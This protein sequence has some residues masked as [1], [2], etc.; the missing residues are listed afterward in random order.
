[1]IKRLSWAA[2]AGALL[3]VIILLLQPAPTE[4]ERVEK[5]TIRAMKSIGLILK[6]KVKTSP[7]L[8]LEMLT[9]RT[10][11]PMGFYNDRFDRGLQRLLELRVVQQRE[12][13]ILQ[14]NGQPAK[15]RVMEMFDTN[16]V[17]WQVTG[18]YTNG[19]YRVI[20]R[21]AV[22]AKWEKLERDYAAKRTHHQST[23]DPSLSK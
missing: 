17:L 11:D 15:V 18:P 8:M 19:L 2:A 7:R 5:E 10:N 23:T 6:K 14:T 16:D 12:F 22:I 1:M 13:L 3:I 21:P 9:L 20:A 4:A